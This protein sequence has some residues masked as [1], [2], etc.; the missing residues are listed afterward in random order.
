M[1]VRL[2]TGA[3]YTVLLLAAGC[4]QPATQPSPPPPEAAAE[5]VSR[6]P[7]QP[8]PSRVALNAPKVELGEQLFHEPMLS[9]DDTI[10]CSS[11]HNLELAGTD[12]RPVSLGLMG[13]PTEFNS[14][15]VF[16]A[17]FNFAQ[18]WNGRAS[19]LEAQI[20]ET[21]HSQIEMGSTWEQIIEKLQAQEHYRRDFASIYADGITATNIKDAI[22]EYE[23]SLITPNSRFDQYLLG[24]EGVLS[25]RELEGYRLFKTYGC[26]TCHQGVGVGGNIF[27]TFGVMGNPFS[28]S[29]ARRDLGRFNV[30]G[31]EHDKFVFKVP[32]LRNVVLTPPYFHDGS[33]ATLTEAVRIMARYQLGRRLAEQDVQ[34]IIAFLATLSGEYQ[35]MPL[36]QTMELAGK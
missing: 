23:R 17:S 11:C 29:P 35:G 27:A 1:N 18:F 10:S 13:Q 36:E 9:T 4:S 22:A 25:E 15:T 24:N 3:A 19:T 6:E 12:R 30:T 28:D 7:I 16:N 31:R 14:P 26:V 2:P 8:I 33:A 5:I 20:E 34:T 32:S 21:T